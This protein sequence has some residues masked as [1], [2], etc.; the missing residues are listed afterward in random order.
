MTVAT[1]HNANTK[2]DARFEGRKVVYKNGTTQYLPCMTSNFTG[3]IT[4]MVGNDLFTM[5]IEGEVLEVK[6]YAAGYG[7]YASVPDRFEPGSIYV[8]RSAKSRED[9]LYG[10]IE[11]ISEHLLSQQ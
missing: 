3:F 1:K 10:L 2:P 5:E 7:F 6:I 11:K 9:A 4:S 8:N